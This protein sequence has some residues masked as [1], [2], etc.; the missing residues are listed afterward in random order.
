MP[1]ARTLAALLILLAVPSGAATQGVPVIDTVSIGHLVTQLS[2]LGQQLTQIRGIATVTDNI[3]ATLG[4]PADVDAFVGRH[5]LPMLRDPPAPSPGTPSAPAWTD[6]AR[7]PDGPTGELRPSNDPDPGHGPRPE[8]QRSAP[9]RTDLVAPDGTRLTADHAGDARAV[10]AFGA[11]HFFI[12]PDRHPDARHRTEAAREL[13][14]WRLHAAQ[15][16][17]LDAWTFATVARSE[18]AAT[19]RSQDRIATMLADSQDIRSDL[20]TLIAAIAE[21]SRILTVANGL[22]AMQLETEAFATIQGSR[23][24]LPAAARAVIDPGPAD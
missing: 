8:W 16:Q 1:R 3:H 19:D 21:N 14:D 13:A 5:V 18:L 22:A 24:V 17:A 2:T 15:Q 11:R 6:P 7:P 4:R 10:R 12:D 23:P 20:A 9:A